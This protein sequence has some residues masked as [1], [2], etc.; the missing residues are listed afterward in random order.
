MK[1]TEGRKAILYCRVSSKKQATSGT[2]LGSQ[3]RACREH[4]RSLGLTV[5]RVFIDDMTGGVTT[6]PGMQQ[7]LAFLRKH[8]KEGYYVVID[9]IERWARDVVSHWQLRASLAEAGGILISPSMEFGDTSDLRLVEN[10]R[11]SVAQHHRDHNRDQTLSRMKSR[12]LNGWWPFAIPLGYRYEKSAGNGKVC[13]RDEPLASTLQEGLEGFAS[14]RFETQADL[15]RFFESRPEFPRDR[16]NRVEYSRV[17][18]LL[19]RVFYAAM[20]DHPRWGI[21]MV[22]ARHEPLITLATWKAIQ[23]KLNGKTKFR[24]RPEVEGEFSLRGS[25][26][27][28]CGTPLTACWSRGSKGKRYAYYL[29]PDRTRACANYGKSIPREKIEGEF[30]TLL[31][32]LTPAP[33]L[34]ALAREAIRDHWEQQTRSARRLIEAGQAE[35]TKVER[36]IDQ[37]LDRIVEADSETVIAAY[38][39]RV[40]SL[41]EQRALLKEQLVRGGEHKP[42]LKNAVR[43]SLAFLSNPCFLWTSGSPS[44]R[45]IAARLAFPNRLTYARNTGFRTPTSASIFRVFSS[46]KNLKTEM[47]HPTRFERVTFAFG[48]QRSIQLSYGCGSLGEA[49]S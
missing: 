32:S 42:S 25:V 7:M 12:A 18:H 38:E 26:L 8:R 33:G 43:T 35:L 27:C 19:A 2:G 30:E 9:D 15:V 13:V 20:I 36:S 21:H 41:E 5:D 40:R 37:L 16:H 49:G 11:A 6:R 17:R 29:C 14:N 23:D 34:I 46:E 1:G 44:E 4:A 10:I 39:R 22:P 24:P 45:R 3:E 48:G 47:A 31:Q 28:E